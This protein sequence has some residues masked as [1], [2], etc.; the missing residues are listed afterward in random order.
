MMRISKARGVWWRREGVSR[1]VERAD[2]I[3]STVMERVMP[4][5]PDRRSPPAG[6]VS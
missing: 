4:A 1:F 3:R 6:G 5:P 2:I